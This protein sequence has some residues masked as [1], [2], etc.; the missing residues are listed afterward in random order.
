M[1]YFFNYSGKNIAIA[2]DKQLY[3][4]QGNHI[5]RYVPGQ[6]IYV[7]LKGNYLGQVPFANRLLRSEIYSF[8]GINFGEIESFGNIGDIGVVGHGG[9]IEPIEG[10]SNISADRLGSLF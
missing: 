3:T 1:E 2:L 6:N 4:P 8:D 7:D 10:F 5:G 9:S